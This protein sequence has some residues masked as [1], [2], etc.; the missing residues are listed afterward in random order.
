[1]A[2]KYCISRNFCTKNRAD[3]KTYLCC[4][5]CTKKT[6][7][8]RCKIFDKE[9]ECDWQVE[10]DWIEQTYFKDT[11]AL[12]TKKTQKEKNEERDKK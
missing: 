5:F 2:K 11:G 10:K 1:M 3:D 12:T 9:G 8:D 7:S 6:C 4:G